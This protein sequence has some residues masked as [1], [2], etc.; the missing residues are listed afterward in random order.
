MIIG[1]PKEIKTN[2]NRVALPPWGVEELVKNG[3]DVLVEI[4]AGANSG[5]KDEDYA[6]AGARMTAAA[7]D[8][9][10]SSQMIVKVKEP[11]G[12]EHKFLREGLL[13]FTYLHL[14]ADPELTNHLLE[15]KV[16]GLAYETLQLDDGSLPLL[17]PMSEIAGRIGAQ[18][19]ACLLEKH[20]GGKGLLIGGAAG[21]PPARVLVLGAGVSGFAAAKICLGMGARVTVFDINVNRLRQI[22][23]ILNGKC[24]TCH[25]NVHN[26]R[27]ALPESDVVIGCVLITGG[28]TPR[29]ITREMLKTMPPGGVLVDISI[30]QGGCFE[31]SRP[32]THENPVYVEEGILHYCVSNM[33]GAVPRTSSIALSDVTLPCIQKI[34][35][36][37]LEKLILEDAPIRKSVNT[38]KGKLTNH[39][40]AEAL[41]LEYSTIHSLININ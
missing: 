6:A 22:D 41:A 35:Q 17:T 16:T 10:N 14:A 13:L 9:W 5:F 21:V 23:S 29:L 2:E 24:T 15:S 33:P 40:V 19:A 31:T 4:S 11:V 8:V 36:Y 1:I 18:Q 28:K 32:T 3:H 39:A 7:A 12:L 34:A 38:Y 27:K 26:I 37:P 25:A 20:H 30:D